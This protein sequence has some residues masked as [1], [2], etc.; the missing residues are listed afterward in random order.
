MARRQRALN[1][2]AALL[3]NQRCIAVL[4]GTATSQ[5]H[6]FGAP[7]RENTK[8]RWKISHHRGHDPRHLDLAALFA[9]LIVIVA[10]Y[11][12]FESSPEKPRPPAFIVPS[13]SVRW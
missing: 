13:Q 11:R 9:L 10:V 7:V 6:W 2:A 8:M 4:S 1:I 3:P 5:A 12:F